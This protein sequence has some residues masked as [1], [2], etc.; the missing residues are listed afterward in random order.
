MTETLPTPDTLEKFSAIAQQYGPFFFAVVFIFFVP[1]MGQRW[2]R[3]FL[4]SRTAS[5][6]ERNAALAAYTFYWKTGTVSGLILVFAA[7]GWWIHVQR[8]YLNRAQL[9]AADKRIISGF[10]L[11]LTED[12]EFIPSIAENKYKMY[13]E[14][15]A[16]KGNT[17]FRYVIIFDDIPAGNELVDFQY[18]PPSSIGASDQVYGA[19]THRLS[20]CI[21]QCNGA[22][23]IIQE[24]NQ[25]PRFNKS[26]GAQT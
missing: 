15:I 11:G 3:S 1:V 22:L 25:S 21:K 8:T 10:I 12:Y 6:E 5:G 20:I 24:K 4:E 17:I 19:K 13:V 7:V 18:L 16:Q 9:A 23:E 26:C 14:K 2:F